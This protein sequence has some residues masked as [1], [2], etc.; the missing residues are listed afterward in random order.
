MALDEITIDALPEV[1]NYIPVSVNLHFYIDQENKFSVLEDLVESH[2][3]EY[4]IHG[5]ITSPFD[6]LLD[7]AGYAGVPDGVGNA[8]R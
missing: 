3:K 2:G 6:Y 8:A 7:L 4:S 1:L 5:E